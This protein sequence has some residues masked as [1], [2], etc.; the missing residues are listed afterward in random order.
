MLMIR[1]NTLCMSVCLFNWES[2]M[3]TQ[4]F[5]T[6]LSLKKQFPRLILLALSWKHV[7]ST[8]AP[9]QLRE[10]EGANVA[11]ESPLRKNDLHT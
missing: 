8:C 5:V 4:V 2:V 6:P 1:E 3:R 11:N 7:L 9:M 10:P